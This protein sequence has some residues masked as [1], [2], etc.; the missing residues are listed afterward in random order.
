[1]EDRYWIVLPRKKEKWANLPGKLEITDTV[2]VNEEVYEF[3]EDYKQLTL[4][5]SI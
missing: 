4:A 1:M 2:Q 5:I 3:I